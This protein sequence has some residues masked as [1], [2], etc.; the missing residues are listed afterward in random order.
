MRFRRAS[1]TIRKR[2]STAGI[3]LLYHRVT[4]LERDPQLLCV[5]PEHFAEHI[6]VLRARTRLVSLQQFVR[7]CAAGF[8]EP[9]AAV[10]F[11][12][13]YADNFLQAK[14]ILERAATPATVFVVSGFVGSNREFWWDE[15][16]RML[17]K[18]EDAGWHVE[19]TVNGPERRR[20]YIEIGQELKPA[21]YTVRARRLTDIQKEAGAGNNGRES[22]RVMTEQEL[23][24]LGDGGLIEVGAHTVTHPQL[25]S[26][27]P[28][29]QEQEI[30][31][32]KRQLEEL[33]GRRI[34]TFAYPYGGT[35]DYTRRSADLVRN[36][37]FSLACSNFPGIVWRTTNKFELPRILVR[38][39][40]G[41]EFGR[42]LH[43]ILQ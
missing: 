14:P 38:D 11:D 7:E 3:I 43:H 34:E 36:A 35:K 2:F 39:W 28:G 20:K 24:L 42:R 9:T 6:D 15:L 17:L 40:D 22:H 18:T 25:S 21:P 41:E 30:K 37:G 19:D 8:K 1:D 13:G 4:K 29:E 10:T 26:L 12:D 27:A 23:R 5:S 33:T 16:D 31:T 32:S